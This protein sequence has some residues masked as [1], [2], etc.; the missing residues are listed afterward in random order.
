MTSCCTACT[1]DQLCKSVNYD[2][3]CELNSVTP[4]SAAADLV[5]DN[6]WTLLFTENH[7]WTTVFRGTAGIGISIEATYLGENLDTLPK[8]E[9]GCY[10]RHPIKCNTHYRSP[11]LDN[12]QNLNIK[13][14]KVEMIKSGVT[15]AFTV[16]TNR[17]SDS[18]TSWFNQDMLSNSSWSDLKTSSYNFF[19]VE[20]E[21][22]TVRRFYMSKRHYGCP[23]DM[24]WWMVVDNIN[25]PLYCQYEKN[26][27]YPT[28]LYIAGPIAAIWESTGG[29]HADVFM[30]SVH[31]ENNV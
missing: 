8:P 9:P 19:N 21:H 10:F 16:F 7:W 30:I 2:Y 26:I 17:A 11:L 25:R 6:E 27:P 3:T 14:V 29:T 20:G 15:G 18:L 23:G 31:M 22:I 24:G 4:D 12:W 5:E 1:I 13:Q 28:F